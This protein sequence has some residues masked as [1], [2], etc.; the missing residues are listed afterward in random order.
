[1]SPKHSTFQGSARRHLSQVCAIFAVACLLLTGYG[2]GA[3][4][5]LAAG[6]TGTQAGTAPP[7]QP[8]TIAA[9]AQNPRLGLTFSNYFTGNPMYARA[10][11]AGAS[12]DRISFQMT[13]LHPTPDTWNWSGYDDLVVGEAAQGLKVLGVLTQP[14]E[15]AA[16]PAYPY[17]SWR[18]PANLGLAWNDPNNYWAQFVYNTVLHYKN[19]IN[20]WQ[21]WNE[22]DIRAYW[23]MPEV[24][25]SLFAQLLR[26]SYQAIKA[27]NPQATVVMAG[28]LYRHDQWPSPI[29]IW[30]AIRALPNSAANKNYFDVMAFHLYDGGTCEH[31]DVIADFRL[32][33]IG[34]DKGGLLDHPIWITESG[35]RHYEGQVS[36]SPGDRFATPDEAAAYVIQNYA[37]ALSKNVP[38]YFYFRTTD[39]DG[40]I[41]R[42]GLIR[43][44]TTLRPA[45]TA[46]QVAAQYLP[47][48]FTSVS[49]PNW[50]PAGSG[51][52]T[53][54]V[55]LITF[56]GTPLGRVSVIWN[57]SASPQTYVFTTI[58]PTFTVVWQNGITA[59]AT[60]TNN[61]YTFNLPPAPNFYLHNPPDDCLVASPPLIIIESDKQPP[62]LTRRVYVP[63]LVRG[64]A[65]AYVDPVVNGSFEQDGGWE[66]NQT[67]YPAAYTSNVVHSGARA[68]QTGIPLGASDPMAPAFS[69]ISQTLQLPAGGPLQLQLWRYAETQDSNDLFYIRLWDQAGTLHTLSETS[70]APSG[71]QQL[72][73]DL[74]P[75][76]GQRITLLL[77][78]QNDGDGLKSV[79]YYDDV[80]LAFQSQ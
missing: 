7:A 45:Y 28:F 17:E 24:P 44:D 6:D 48:T 9:I 43:T 60:A 46:F 33:M 47:I 63:F 77:G 54:P 15:W 2:T 62:I 13:A 67:A 51:V 68:T 25:A 75:Y 58:R 36:R 40:D 5:S 56:N 39:T 30:Q 16:N 32:N 74:T 80:T 19:S 49:R 76:A 3:N 1:V 42:W 41:N 50:Y 10:R 61:K 57:V 29:T 37:Y 78:T 59:T 79:A 31:F 14:P 72:S 73:F 55:S 12:Y 65:S 69:S 26:V 52:V 4:P 38:R 18:V 53:N 11:E 27:A 70:A 21:V 35:I 66:I 64:P 34:S 71:W 8:D 22:P 23:K 20:M